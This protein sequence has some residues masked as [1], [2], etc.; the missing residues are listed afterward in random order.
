MLGKSSGLLGRNYEHGGKGLS[1]C[2]EKVNDLLGK[3]ERHTGKG[4]MACWEGGMSVL[5]TGK[6][7][8]RLGRVAQPAGKH[9]GV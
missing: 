8:G 6:D 7:E 3:A 9:G 1:T 5:G 4:C 2:W